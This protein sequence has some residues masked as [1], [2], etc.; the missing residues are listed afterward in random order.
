MISTSRE[1][2][3]L[4]LADPV[5][6][7]VLRIGIAHVLQGWLTGQNLSS[8][9]DT[10]E[11]AHHYAD[12]EVTAAHAYAAVHGLIAREVPSLALKAHCGALLNPGPSRSSTN[13]EQT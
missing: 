1:M 8:D 5:D 12:I 7:A 3:G 10:L 2:L 11:Y 9:S 6:L 4:R 13:L